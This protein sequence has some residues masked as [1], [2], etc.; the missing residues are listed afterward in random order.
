MRK[1]EMSTAYHVVSL[2]SGCG[3]ADLGFQGGFTYLGDTFQPLPFRI[4]WANDMD[5]FAA[6]VYRHNLA[7]ISE[8][9]ISE[10]NFETLDLPLTDVLVA[11]IPCQATGAPDEDSLAGDAA[12]LHRERPASHKLWQDDPVLSFI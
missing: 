11:G 12:V 6:K 7:E 5:G 9:D 2:F 1:S 3:G 10:V 8:S 4:S